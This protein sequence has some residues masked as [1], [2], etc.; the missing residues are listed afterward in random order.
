[1]SAGKAI[2]HTSVQKSDH[3]RLK[4][5]YPRAHQIKFVVPLA[6]F[7]IVFLSNSRRRNGR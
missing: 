2:G 4:S 3:R 7:P 1:M 6:M 5:P